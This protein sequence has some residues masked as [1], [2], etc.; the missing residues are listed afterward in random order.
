MQSSFVPCLV[1]AFIIFVTIALAHDLAMLAA[2]ALTPW[3]G[4]MLP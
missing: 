2:R 1:L 4:W 3:F